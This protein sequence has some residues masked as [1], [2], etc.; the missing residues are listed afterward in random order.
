MV[1]RSSLRL[2]LS[3]SNFMKTIKHVLV[4]AVLITNGILF[5]ANNP[6]PTSGEELRANLST[7]LT[8]LLKNPDISLESVTTTNVKLMINDQNQLVVLSIDSSDTRIKNY[9]TSR[10]N[11]RTVKSVNG[12][13]RVF[14]LPLKINVG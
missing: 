6:N 4:I 12:Q 11:Y 13:N 7:E 10:L 9:V 14:V 1:E 8:T 2:S 5:A 3:N